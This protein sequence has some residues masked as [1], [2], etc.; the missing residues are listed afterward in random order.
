MSN[1]DSVRSTRVPK[2]RRR[3]LIATVG[4]SDYG[5][6]RPVLKAI[7]EHPDLV[8]SL[9][10][11]GA[12]LN[13]ATAVSME[14]I[15][16]D[17]YDIAARVPLPETSGGSTA[18]TDAM[19]AAIAGAG[20][21][22]TADP[23]DMLL[24][25]GDRFEMFAIA[26]AAVPCN[27]PI[28][29]IHGGELSFGA[30][31]DVF[32]HAITKMAHLHFPAT[33]GYGRRIRQMGEEAWRIK[34]V[35][36]PALDTALGHALP[37]RATLAARFH[38]P[39]ENRPILATYH[40]VTRRLEDGLR[41]LRNVLLALKDTG[42]TVII[43]GPNADAGADAMRAE[44][45]TAC[46]AYPCFHFV[47]SFGAVSYLAML[48][49]AGCVVGNSSSGIIETPFFKVPT[50]NIGSR[51]DGRTRAANV[52]DCGTDQPEIAIALAKALSPEFRSSLS[53]MINPYGNG[54]AG[55]QIAEALAEVEL[56][57]RLLEKRF[58]DQAKVT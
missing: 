13:G 36:A 40:P 39:L 51:Q 15:A 18:V 58:D 20:R 6:F 4:R 44:I 23:P 16:S 49:E 24:V 21:H 33:E 34:V 27:V 48:R 57:A 17:G 22:F 11:S 19:A 29:H 54:T 37:D 42:Q 1:I 53:T 55:V 47:E 46:R 10:V 7:R 41:E 52:I 8:P 50:V 38:L 3:V 2:R 9:L 30:I 31:D 25:L 5:I 26:A 32:R 35:G 12:H 56:G 14:E 28:G 45:M 43:T